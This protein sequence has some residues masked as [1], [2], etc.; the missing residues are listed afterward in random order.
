MYI[1]FFNIQSIYI[2]LIVYKKA[3]ESP[4]GTPKEM[5]F[6]KLWFMYTH[7][8]HQNMVDGILLISFPKM[9]NTWG[10]SLKPT[11]APRSFWFQVNPKIRSGERGYFLL[12]GINLAFPLVWIIWLIFP[13]SSWCTRY[14]NYGHRCRIFNVLGL[15]NSRMSWSLMNR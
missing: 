6:F 12:H 9:Y 4:K 14:N 8:V 10:V 3:F 11:E 15:E 5:M 13:L 2:M 7:V 1:S